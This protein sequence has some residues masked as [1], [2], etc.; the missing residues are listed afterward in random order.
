M[1]YHC[2]IVDPNRLLKTEMLVLSITI[3]LR[4]GIPLPRHIIITYKVNEKSQIIFFV[5]PGSVIKIGP[6]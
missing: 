6:S 5:H 2:T 4:E 3:A 1:Y